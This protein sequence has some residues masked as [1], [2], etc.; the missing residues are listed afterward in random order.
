MLWRTRKGA[1]SLMAPK[2]ARKSFWMKPNL[3]YRPSLLSNIGLCRGSFLCIVWRAGTVESHSMTCCSVTALFATGKGKVGRESLLGKR[4]V[5]CFRWHI[6]E[7]FLD[8]HS[9]TQWW[10]R[11]LKQRR[12]SCI[13]ACLLDCSLTTVYSSGLWF[14]L[15][16]AQQLCCG[17]GHLPLGC[18]G[19]FWLELNINEAMGKARLE[20]WSSGSPESLWQA[21]SISSSLRV[22][23]W[24]SSNV[25]SLLLWTPARF[26]FNSTGNF[27]WMIG[28]KIP[29]YDS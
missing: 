11:Q 2:V 12:A 27:F 23:L 7:R 13:M 4:L 25:H 21:L 26:L 10:Q 18:G 22:T 8:L 9:V 5:W 16:K 14:P 1:K 17:G 6:L 3:F 20:L 19:V 28:S 15:Q 24:C 29:P